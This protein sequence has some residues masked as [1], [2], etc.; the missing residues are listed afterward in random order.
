M[1]ARETVR[2]SAGGHLSRPGEEKFAL[3]LAL[4]FDSLGVPAIFSASLPSFIHRNTP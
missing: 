3:P 4:T 2:L 1:H